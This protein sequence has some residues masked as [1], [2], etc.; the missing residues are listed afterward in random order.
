MRGS[1]F[2]SIQTQ[3]GYLAIEQAFHRC[4]T[5][6]VLPEG[7]T[8][9]GKRWGGR[10]RS[11]SWRSRPRPSW[12]RILARMRSSTTWGRFFWLHVSGFVSYLFSPSPSPSPSPATQC[13][14][15]G[16]KERRQRGCCCF[17]C[18]C[19]LLLLLNLIEPHNTL[20]LLQETHFK[21]ANH[22]LFPCHYRTSSSAL[23]NDCSLINSNWHTQTH[24]HLN[25]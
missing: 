16:A 23:Q 25:T 24:S 21:L 4:V 18:F 3:A 6:D 8:Q 10:G 15:G 11:S 9:A 1:R 14:G 2:T 7:P 20:Y 5:Q 19:S 13:G 12:E 22:N 17:C